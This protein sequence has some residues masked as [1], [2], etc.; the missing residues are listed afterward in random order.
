M[1]SKRGNMTRS[2]R[3]VLGMGF[4]L[5]A[6]LAQL[7][8]AGPY[9]AKADTTT[10]TQGGYTLN[11]TNN[12]PA[13]PAT[14]KQNMINTFFTIYPQEVSRFN[15]NSITTV[16]WII[17]PNYT[18]VAAAGGGQVTYGANYMKTHAADYDVVTHESMHIVQNYNCGAVPGWLTE[19]IADYARYKYG[20]NNAAAGWSLGNYSAGQ[21]YTNAYRVTA[22]FLV[23]MEQRV[24]STIVTE[25]NASARTCTYTSNT[26]VSLTGKTVD[27]N[28]TSY[29]QDP[30]LTGTLPTATKTKTPTTGTGPTAT[31]TATTA[32]GTTTWA[33]NVAYAVN[34]QVSYAG[35]NY[36]CLQAHTSLVGWEPPNVPA[37]WQRI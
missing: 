21:S 9:L 8:L 33:P 28:W 30:S 11:I 15:T 18:G 19:G 34:A 13:F 32:T 1:M 10:V 6:L 4:A 17:D 26:W 14:L 23:W 27:Q 3:W 36:K 31:K 20:V 2:R 24:R 25:L 22:R 16:K 37:L 12:D 29:T 7:M 35:L 5:V